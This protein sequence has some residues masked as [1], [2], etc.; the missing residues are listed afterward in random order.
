MGTS[1]RD[2]P[3]KSRRKDH[4]HACGDKSGQFICGRCVKGSS[5]RV[6]G[7]VDCKSHTCGR[8]W[9]IPTRVGTRVIGAVADVST[10]DHPHACGDKSRMTLR[11]PFCQGSSPRVWGQVSGVIV[12]SV[13]NRIIPTRVGTRGYV[14]PTPANPEDHP[15]ACGD[16]IPVLVTV[17]FSLGSSPRVWGQEVSDEKENH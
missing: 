10:E 4:P 14:Q 17:A 5:P 15:H 11:M 9:I 2:S 12:D 6:W 1:K 16:K 7:Q 8:V 13:R 3:Q